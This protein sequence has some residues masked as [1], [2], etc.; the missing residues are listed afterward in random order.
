M[1]RWGRYGAAAPRR[2]GEGVNLEDDAV[3]VVGVRGRTR[4]AQAHVTERRCHRRVLCMFQGWLL[5]HEELV[6]FLS[7]TVNLFEEGHHRGSQS[8]AC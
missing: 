7:S 3:L 5:R 2:G 8:S 6:S 4:Y 1:R